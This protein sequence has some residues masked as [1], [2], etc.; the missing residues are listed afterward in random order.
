MRFD[1][2]DLAL[3]VATTKIDLSLTDG[4]TKMDSDK[5]DKHKTDMHIMRLVLPDLLLLPVT[6]TDGQTEK[7]QTDTVFW[8]PAVATSKTDRHTDTVFLTT[9]V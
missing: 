8:Q 4:Q 1:L 7:R 9:A 6:Q 3:A 2:L 5:T